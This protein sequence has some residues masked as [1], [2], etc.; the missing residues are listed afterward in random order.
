[1]TSCRGVLIAGV[2]NRA[3][4][5]MAEGFLRALTGGRIFIASGGVFP[6]GLV[7]PLAVR[8]M[9]EIGL[10]IS[11]LSPSSLESARRKS[12]TY[13]VYISIDAPYAD[14]HADRHHR[15]D[16]GGRVLFGDPALAMGPPAHW[17]IAQDAA[18]VRSGFHLWSPRDP[19]IYYENST[20]KFQDHLYEGEPLFQRLEASTMRLDARVSGRWELTEL[21]DPFAMERAGHHLERFRQARAKLAAESVRL[22][23]QLE[24]YY[25][26]RLLVDNSCLESTQSGGPDQNSFPCPAK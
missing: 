23:R 2:T 20:R 4:T 8:S 19:A 9:A 24:E 26:E 15:K 11:I 17:T 25:G 10:D 21:S 14:R 16:D 6:H 1:M 22:L 7:H 13:D 18:D 12:R 3:R 5:L